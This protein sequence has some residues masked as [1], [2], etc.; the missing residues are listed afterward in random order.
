VSPWVAL[1]AGVPVIALGMAVLWLVQR[2]T[3]DA[4]VVDVG[5][6]L[7]VGLLAVAVALAGPGDPARRLLMAALVGAW[8]LRLAFH[9]LVDRVLPPGE[10]GR[11]AMLRDR[12]GSRQQRNM[13]LFFQAQA[14]FA[15]AFAI[16][17]AVIATNPRPLGALDALAVL[18][19]IAGLAGETLAD[20]QL[21]RFKADPSHRGTTCRAGLWSLSRH[22]NY[23]F[24][25]I[26]W[27]AYA[28]LAVGAPL[29]WLAL[30][31][32]LLMLW[33]LLR[34]TG[35][36]YTEKRALQSRGEDYARYQREVSAFVPWFPKR[37][38]T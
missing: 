22:P 8:A 14:I 4:A 26:Q 13:L 30:S 2:R 6:S 7:S 12:W 27:I 31:G 24:E 28:L 34:V 20:A 9:L 23:F 37:T 35:I 16:P 29:A 36:P 10:D 21:A 38:A 5:W 1:L 25:W 3:G 33:F 11:Y 32:P 15:G 18:V 17:F 19:W